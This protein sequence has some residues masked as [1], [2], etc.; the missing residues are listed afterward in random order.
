MKRKKKWS[1][2]IKLICYFWKKLPD[3]CLMAS[4]EFCISWISNLGLTFS[5]MK[6]LSKCS[7]KLVLTVLFEIHCDF[8]IFLRIQQK[9]WKANILIFSQ[10]KMCV[11]EKFCPF[12]EL[13]A[14]KCT[15]LISGMH[16]LRSWILHL[17]FDYFLNFCWDIFSIIKL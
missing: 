12:K 6:T 17:K 1:N 16:F 10:D 8:F 2:Y 7:C 9:M 14:P 13:S 4:Q 15:R 11:P 5:D 3:K